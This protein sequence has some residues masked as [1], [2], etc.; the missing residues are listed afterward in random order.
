[1]AAG[2]AR[3]G[4]G[5]ELEDEMENLDF[6]PR[7]CGY[8]AFCDVYARCIASFRNSMFRCCPAQLPVSAPSR[9]RPDARSVL[10]SDCHHHRL[11]PCGLLFLA[12]VHFSG[13]SMHG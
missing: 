6:L 4:V 9:V 5:L 2:V 1:M 8:G 3:R 12:L 7:V 13:L 11:P 10:L